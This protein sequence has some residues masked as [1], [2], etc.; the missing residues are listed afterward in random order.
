MRAL[1]RQKQGNLL[2]PAWQKFLLARGK[3]GRGV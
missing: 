1:R 3:T 2:L